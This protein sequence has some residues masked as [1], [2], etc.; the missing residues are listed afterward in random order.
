MRLTN[1]F[2]DNFFIFLAKEFME[3]L[4]TKRLLVLIC[5]FMFFAI[6]GPVLTRYMPEIFALLIPAGDE[7]G[8]AMLD[9]MGE[10]TW[11]DSFVQLYGNLG[12]IGS[13]TVILL[14]MGAILREKRSGTADIM[15][16][17]SLTPLE[18]VLAKYASAALLVLGT[19][20]LSIFVSTVYTFVLFGEIGSI[21]D[22][23]LGSLAFSAF[24]LFMLAITLLCSAYAKSTGTAAVFSLMMWAF[25]GFIAVLPRIGIYTPATLMTGTP[26]ALT[27]GTPPQ[28]VWITLIVTLVL[29][30]CALLLATRIIT[31]R[32]S[33]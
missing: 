16:S 24:L 22:I 15:L 26:A 3:N 2:F 29:A 11:Q 13:L 27:L 7:M 19:V 21:V 18:F 5:V 33:G 25:F 32:Q 17:K 9:V 6:S 1:N 12:Q 30:D 20:V 31:K 23:L 4:R 14:F 8:Q 28:G 10:P